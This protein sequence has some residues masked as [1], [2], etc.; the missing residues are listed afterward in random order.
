M[1]VVLS[2]SHRSFCVKLIKGQSRSRNDKGGIY[3]D[4]QSV[5][6]ARWN[7][8]CHLVMIRKYRC[9]VMY[10]RVRK[11]VGEIS[12][13]LSEMSK[14]ELIGE[15][16]RSDYVHMYVSVPPRIMSCFKRKSVLMLFTRHL[17]FKRK[18]GRRN[19]RA[20]VYYAITVGNVNEGMR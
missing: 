18:Y 15:K 17:E 6:R 2:V 7:C 9:K 16:I 12:R 19:F 11:G 8:A 10:G 20:R 4:N 14:S 1:A 13:K 3:M 5:A